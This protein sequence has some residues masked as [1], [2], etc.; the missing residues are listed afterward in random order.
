MQKHII[1]IWVENQTGVLSRIAGLFSEMG[2]NIDSLAVGV[3]EKTDVSRMTLVA[4]GS[5]E[6]VDSI[7]SNLNKITSLIKIK[8]ISEKESVLRELALIM[9]E[10]QEA[11]RS[12]IINIVEIFRAQIVDV[13]FGTMTVEVCGDAEKIQAIEDLLHPFGI[14]EIVRTGTIA[15]D[16]G[17]RRP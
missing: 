10:A 4:N 2:S 9:V 8:K 17:N 1:S 7:L 14:R 5:D 13:G 12:D 6:L 11:K 16:R 3:T 15:I